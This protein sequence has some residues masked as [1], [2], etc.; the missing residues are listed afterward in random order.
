ML[1]TYRLLFV[2]PL[3]GLGTPLRA[4]S[5]P[6][7]VTVTGRAV[8]AK[9]TQPLRNAVVRIFASQRATLTDS[10]GNF[11]FA[12]LKPG[13]H[14]LQIS[15]LGYE[16]F[17]TEADIVSDTTLSLSVTQRRISPE[18]V[19]RVIK[20]L[21]YRRS[22]AP[23]GVRVYF[24]SKLGPASGRMSD[25]LGSS[26]QVVVKTCPQ[27]GTRVRTVEM[28]VYARGE[29]LPINLW[30]DEEEVPSNLLDMY[31]PREFDQIELYG[32]SMLR[33]YSRQFLE[34][35]ALGKAKLKVVED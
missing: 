3:L 16:R 5:A 8:D 24:G 4:Q 10:L 18:D 14:T 13:H 33:L 30:V 12:S 23:I 28:C 35:V 34:Q 6:E 15:R 27:P 22:R 32:N 9:T 21:D 7:Q 2:V 20:N 17:D 1:N 26:A 29:S 31:Y 11:V 25:F 19:S